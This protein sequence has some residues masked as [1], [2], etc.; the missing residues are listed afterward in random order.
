MPTLGSL[1]ALAALALFSVESA[2]VTR[3]DF[4]YGHGDDGANL[5]FRYFVPPGYDSAQAY[6]LILFL[7]GSGERGDDNE[8]QLDNDANGAM[9]LLGDDDLALQPVFMIA[10]Q[11]PADSWWSGATLDSAIDLIDQ[12]A[13][14][15]HIDPDRIY[16]TGVSMGGMGTWSA[17]AAQPG[18]FAAAVPMS[19]EGD[20]AAVTVVGT[21]PFWFFHAADDPIVDVSG[22]DDLVAALRDAGDNVIYTR[23]DTGG[24]AIWPVAYAHPLLF[25]WW[26]AQQRGDTDT[27]AAPVLRITSPS[28]A[29]GWSTTG[30]TIDLGGSADHADHPIDAVSWDVAGGDNGSADGSDRW[31]SDDIPLDNGE[32]LIR[33]IATAPTLHA[34]YGGHTSF[35]DSVWVNRV[36]DRIFADSFGA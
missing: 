3:D 4:L 30:A 34:D 27:V 14:N 13:A 1:A 25:P 7:H 21:V 6:P 26:V 12:V 29:D 32:N 16:V 20:S 23:Y 9:A 28:S 36:A 5:P 24:H 33:L 31:R 22:S 35:N 2:A 10:P 8:A 17:V 15:Y 18:R 19:G 11:C